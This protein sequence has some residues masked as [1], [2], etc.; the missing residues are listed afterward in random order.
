MKGLLPIVTLVL[1]TVFGFSTE[2]VA[3]YLLETPDASYLLAI[4]KDPTS[5]ESTTAFSY[6]NEEYRITGNTKLFRLQ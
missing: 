6:S 4:A 3:K 5:K 1:F 2:G